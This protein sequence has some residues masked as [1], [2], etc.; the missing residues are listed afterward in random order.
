MIGR[1]VREYSLIT[2]PRTR[3]VVPAVVPA[4]M[5]NVSTVTDGGGV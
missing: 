2:P 4:W 5:Q 1:T 3:A